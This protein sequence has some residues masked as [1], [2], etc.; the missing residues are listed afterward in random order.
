MGD[1]RSIMD[2]L[3]LIDL[4]SMGLPYTWTNCRHGRANIREK[5]DRGIVNA[6]WR[7]L[8]PRASVKN[9]PITS[10]DHAPLLIDTEG[11]S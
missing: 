9:L 10:S 5:L 4:G 2:H 7:S 1:L 8:F 11:R 6:D 3:G